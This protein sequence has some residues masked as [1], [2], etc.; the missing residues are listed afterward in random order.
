M[1]EGADIKKSEI[2]DGKM[3]CDELDR[4]VSESQIGA[5]STE[6][7]GEVSN[8]EALGHLYSMDRTIM[9]MS[10]VR[11]KHYAD[12]DVY[13]DDFRVKLTTT[14]LDLLENKHGFN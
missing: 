13:L 6:D 10:V 8:L 7:G 4:G 1:T 11:D 12:L 9:Q 2:D 5:Q 3:V 14:F